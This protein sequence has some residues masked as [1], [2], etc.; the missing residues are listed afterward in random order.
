MFLRYLNIPSWYVYYFIRKHTHGNIKL[1]YLKSWKFK[2]GKV[3]NIKK[4][5]Q[6]N[7][8]ILFLNKKLT[9]TKVY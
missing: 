4:K 2:E 6:K 7:P 8:I 3:G 5:T 9:S 1:G